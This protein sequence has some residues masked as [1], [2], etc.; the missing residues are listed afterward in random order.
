MKILKFKK[1]PRGK[2][3]VYFDNNSYI[4][5]YEDVIINNNLLITKEVDDDKLEELIKE[6][7]DYNAYFIALNYISIKMRS[8]NELNNYLI[9]KQ[10]SEKTIEKVIN[11]LEKEGYLNDFKFAKAYTN[12]Q[13]LITNKGPLKIRLELKKYGIKDEIIEEVIEEIDKNILKEKLSNL[14]AKQFKIKKG[15]SNSLKIKLINYF[16][17]L[18]YDKDMILEEISN[19]KFKSDP[20]RLQKDYEKLYNRYKSKYKDNDLL[21]F[22][23]NKLY[24]KGYNSDDIKTVI[25]SNNLK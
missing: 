18:G 7:S 5:L 21:Y 12:D 10:V 20:I 9:R 19:Y 6:N 13:V 17:N 11:R 4:T 8:I 14:M 24:L 15:S 16:T 1:N 23:S 3:K 2:Y 25:E 22:I